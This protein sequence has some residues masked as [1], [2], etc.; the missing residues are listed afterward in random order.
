MKMKKIMIAL[1]AVALTVSA[2]A[3]AFSWKT[4]A[5]GKIYE[6]G[7]TTVLASGTAYLFDSAAVSQQAVLDAVL[8]GG[9]LDSLASLSNAK[10]NAGKISAT[11][12]DWGAAGDTLNAYVAIVDGDNVYIGN[13]VSATGDASAAAALNLKEASSSQAAAME[14]TTFSSA[15]WYTAAAV[16]EP[17]SGLLMLVGLA[18]LALRRR[19]A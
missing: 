19:R 8:G 15:G 9:T 12:F 1:A 17:T 2:Q 6:A 14:S 13:I 11:T 4:A 5:T 3:A 10:V 18:G 16:P 7:T